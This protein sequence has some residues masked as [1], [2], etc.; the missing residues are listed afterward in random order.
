MS[1]QCLGEFTLWCSSLVLACVVGVSLTNERGIAIISNS[2]NV[3]VKE[4]SAPCTK[5]STLVPVAL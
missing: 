2:E 3:S 1:P 5:V 4:A